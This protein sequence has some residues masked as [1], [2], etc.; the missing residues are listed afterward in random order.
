MKLIC[1]EKPNF[2]KQSYVHILSKGEKL[3][4]FYKR[5]CVLLIDKEQTSKCQKMANIWRFGHIRSCKFWLHRQGGDSCMNIGLH[6]LQNMTSVCRTKCF[7]KNAIVD[8]ALSARI[9]IM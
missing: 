4:L 7:K 2:H 9:L 1:V 5:K 3:L 8:T 6:L